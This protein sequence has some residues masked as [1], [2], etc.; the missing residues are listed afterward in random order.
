MHEKRETGGNNNQVASNTRVPRAAF[1]N[2]FPRPQKGTR[3]E[4]VKDF[5]QCSHCPKRAPNSRHCSSTENDLRAPFCVHLSPTLYQ[6]QKQAKSAVSER[7]QRADPKICAQELYA[8]YTSSAFLQC[9]RHFWASGS[10]KLHRKEPPHC[11]PSD[12]KSYVAGAQMHRAGHLG[13]ECYRNGAVLAKRRSTS[14]HEDAR[15]LHVP[16]EVCTCAGHP[17][18]CSCNS[19]LHSESS[20]LAANM[21]FLN[22]QTQPPT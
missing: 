11:P 18:H 1:T 12:I 9:T 14:L 22:Y 6:H 10:G 4:L 15:A 7:H 13:C 8:K 3:R 20:Q 5:S 2:H 16:Q 19:L 17:K 21:I